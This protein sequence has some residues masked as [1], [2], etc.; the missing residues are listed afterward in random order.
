M[1]PVKFPPFAGGQGSEDGVLRNRLAHS[2]LGIA[3]GNHALHVSDVFEDLRRQLR[4]GC[5]PGQSVL[6]GFAA[7]RKII[8]PEDYAA[9]PTLTVSI[10][11]GAGSPRR[12]ATLAIFYGTA[13]GL[14]QMV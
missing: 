3:L 13:V 12:Q 4:R 5:T 8:E 11:A 7:V 6:R 9:L 2:E 14:V 10:D 1:Q